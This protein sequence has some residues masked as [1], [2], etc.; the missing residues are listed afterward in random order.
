MLANADMTRKRD[1][2]NRVSG[3]GILG[4]AFR[5]LEV[6]CLGVYACQANSCK[7]NILLERVDPASDHI[8]ICQH[9]DFEP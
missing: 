9:G 4:L 1:P 2:A 7:Q 6:V 8:C 3:L 5:D